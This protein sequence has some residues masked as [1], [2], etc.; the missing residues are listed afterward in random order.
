MTSDHAKGK[1]QGDQDYYQ[2][3]PYIWFSGITAARLPEPAEP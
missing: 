2:V 3:F 1:G